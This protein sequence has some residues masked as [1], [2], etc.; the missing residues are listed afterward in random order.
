MSD[1]NERSVASAGSVEPVAWA[2]VSDSREE[3][4][5]EFVYPDKAT[6]GDVALD[7]NGGLVPLYRQ[8]Q[9]TLTNEERE[10]VWFFAA[11]DSNDSVLGSHAATLRALLE[12]TK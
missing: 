1:T 4:D 12:R 8:P 6:A 2:V 7:I 9:P 5:C 10:A 3:I 11:I